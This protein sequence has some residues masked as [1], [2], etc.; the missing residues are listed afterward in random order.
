[1]S[2]KELK[3]K[4]EKLEQDKRQTEKL[5]NNICM[6]LLSLRNE[7]EHKND[8]GSDSFI[9]NSTNMHKNFYICTICGHIKSK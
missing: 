8:D 1:M 3:E 6:E 4:R 5:L 2:T 9:Y 7:C